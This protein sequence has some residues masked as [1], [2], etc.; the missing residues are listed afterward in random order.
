M[1]TC[2]PGAH[3]WPIFRL[4]SYLAWRPANRSTRQG[5]AWP[6][7]TLIAVFRADFS[8]S[9]APVVL[10]LPRLRSWVLDRSWRYAPKYHQGRRR[11]HTGLTSV[12]FYTDAGVSMLGPNRVQPIPIRRP[13]TYL[14]SMT[15]HLELATGH[16]FSSSELPN[17]TSWE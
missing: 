16:S 10:P 9:G 2:T 1:H 4:Q 12:D 7:C 8:S 11:P 13:T 3:G 6:R 5:R 17:M 14:A 15:T